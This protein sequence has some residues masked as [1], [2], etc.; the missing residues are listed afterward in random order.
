MERGPNGGYLAALLL[1]AL[2]RTRELGNQRVRSYQV[3]FLEVPTLGA[4]DID[5]RLELRKESACVVS[6]V[7]RQGDRTCVLGSIATLSDRPSITFCP[8][9]SPV[10]GRA[11]DY[12]RMRLPSMPPLSA[13]YDYRSLHATPSSPLSSEYVGGF[14]RLEEPQGLDPQALT[15]FCDAW[16]PASYAHHPDPI[17][18]SSIELTVHFRDLATLERLLPKDFVYCRFQARA[19]QESLVD[20]DGEL[21]SE[22]GHLLA[23]CRQL[24]LATRVPG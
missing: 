1:D 2:L 24:R 23:Q 9:A 18:G 22:D 12:P 20:E 16:F 3:R 11:L 17:V 4:T 13:N 21:W 15:A 7:L 10:P 19:A 8:A 6:G 5:T 14:L